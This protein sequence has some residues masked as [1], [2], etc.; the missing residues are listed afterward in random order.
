MS[1]AP[2]TDA[3]RR[4][5]TVDALR[6]DVLVAVIRG[7]N[8]ASA[9]RAVDALVAGGIRGIEVT[10]T[11]PGA[12]EVIAE[13]AGRYGD[14]ITLGAGTVTTAQQAADAVEA[15]AGF[16]VSPGTRPGLAAAMRETGAALLLGALTPS[17]VM[18]SRDEGADLVKLFPASLGGPGFLRSLR[19][20]FPD[21]DFCPTGG[22]NPQTIPG[23]LDAGA[24][25]LGAGGELCPAAKVAAGDWAGIT[26]LAREFVAALP[27]R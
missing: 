10:Y 21:V 16:L 20:P 22:V 15:G 4:T 13:L 12:T 7:A 26:E 11:T 19:G 23:W 17:E 24:V 1:A 5:S 6:R 8:S 3:G 27:G 2:G 14:E 9:V 18:A 25:A